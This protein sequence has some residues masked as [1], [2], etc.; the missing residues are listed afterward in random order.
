MRDRDGKFLGSN[1]FRYQ[2]VTEDTL[3]VFREPVGR[4]AN[5]V[6]VKE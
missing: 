6:E 4:V 3:Q 1:G 2:V 5:R